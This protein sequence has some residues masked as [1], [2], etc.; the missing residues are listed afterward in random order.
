LPARRVIRKLEPGNG[1][2]ELLEKFEHC[3]RLLSTLHQ[4][5]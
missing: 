3:P 2:L 1:G 5:E 4:L